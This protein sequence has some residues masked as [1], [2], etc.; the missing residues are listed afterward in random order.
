MKCNNATAFLGSKRSATACN[1]VSPNLVWNPASA[2]CIC[3]NSTQIIVASGSTYTCRDCLGRYTLA[4]NGL[5]TCSCLGTGLV[6]TPSS[7]GGACACP[8]GNILLSNFSCFRCPNTTSTVSTTYECRCNNANSIWNTYLLRC[9]VC[10]GAEIPNSISGG[11][12]FLTCRCRTGFIWD[13]VTQS[14]I[15]TCT[16]NNSTCLACN[17]YTE[18]TGEAFALN[19]SNSRTLTGSSTVQQALNFAYTNFGTLRNFQCGC[20]SGQIWDPIRLRCFDI[21]LV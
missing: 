10:G 14:C 19:S 15:T 21:N 8:A 16:A 12:S 9:Q 7:A 4:P 17:Y 13:V 20:I 3:A 6:F 18:T 1:C 5:T 2:A 11:G